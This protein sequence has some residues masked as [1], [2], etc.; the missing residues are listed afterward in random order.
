MSEMLEEKVFRVN[1][2]VTKHTFSLGLEDLAVWGAV[3]SSKIRVL[4]SYIPYSVANSCSC[5]FIPFI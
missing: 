1:V 4:Q 2:A 5:N 3:V